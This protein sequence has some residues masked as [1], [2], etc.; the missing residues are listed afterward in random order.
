MKISPYSNINPIIYRGG[1]T[2]VFP[3]EHVAQEEIE[4][5]ENNTKIFIKD[6]VHKSLSLTSLATMGLGAY[7]LKGSKYGKFAGGGIGLALGVLLSSFEDSV[8]HRLQKWLDDNIKH[9]ILYQI[10]LLLNM[11]L[12]AAILAGI[13][14]G[15]KMLVF[16]KGRQGSTPEEQFQSAEKM[17]GEFNYLI[18]KIKPFIEKTCASEGHIVQ[19]PLLKPEQDALAFTKQMADGIKEFR[20]SVKNNPNLTKASSLS[21]QTSAWLTENSM[22]HLKYYK[23]WHEAGKLTPYAAARDISPKLAFGIGVALVFEA[24][25]KITTKLLN[26]ILP[27]RHIDDTIASVAP[28]HYTTISENYYQVRNSLTNIP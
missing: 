24:G 14:I 6:I 2:S 1:T 13:G 4:D 20:Q 28:T 10:G 22:R 18:K 12:T 15:K 7:I 19:V 17:R 27:W 26:R 25:L 8:H 3:G 23:H 5:N 9:P 11:S 21:L 16:A